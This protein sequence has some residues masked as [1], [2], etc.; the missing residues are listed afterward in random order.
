VIPAL[1][2]IVTAKAIVY[3]SSATSA[4]NYLWSLVLYTYYALTRAK[5]LT[6]F[7]YKATYSSLCFSTLAISALTTANLALFYLIYSSVSAI[8]LTNAA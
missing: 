5:S 6:A 3:S 8:Y 4:K 1:F 7:L 2:K